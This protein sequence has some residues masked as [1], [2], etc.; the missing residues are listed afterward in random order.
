MPS[1]NVL[2]E[3]VFVPDNPNTGSFISYIA[4]VIGGIAFITTYLLIQK[5]K[6]NKI[7]W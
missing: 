4:I 7:K 3:A 6:L 1:A 2:I 5:S